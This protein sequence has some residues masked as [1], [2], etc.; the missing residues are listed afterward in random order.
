ME[1]LPN[2]QPEKLDSLR[3]HM[4]ND[5][6]IG[7]LMIVRLIVRSLTHQPAPPST[8]SIWAN[9]VGQRVHLTLCVLVFFMVGSDLA[10]AVETE[11][12]SIL[13]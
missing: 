11:L 3:G 4:I 6:A 7:V 1:P 5:L 13:F 12:P 9:R 2:S 10:L 8:G